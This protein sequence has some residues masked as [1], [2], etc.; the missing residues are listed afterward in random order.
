MD[1][2]VNARRAV[3]V[4]QAIAVLYILLYVHY[5]LDWFKWKLATKN[6]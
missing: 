4:V 2:V 6:K 1:D 5:H 3:A